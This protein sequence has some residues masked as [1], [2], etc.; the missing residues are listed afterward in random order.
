MKVV[1]AFVPLNVLHLSQEAY[2]GYGRRLQD[3]CDGR[4]VWFDDWPLSECWLYKWLTDY[5]GDPLALPPATATPADRY[6]DPS[7]HVKSN[8]V[9]HSRTQWAKLAA[10][11]YVATDVFVWLDL[12]LLKQGS[13]TGKQITEQHV[14]DFLK[15]VED[16][17]FNDTIPFPG[18]EERKPVDVHGNNWRF[19]GCTHIWPRWALPFIDHAYKFHCRE[20]IRDHQCIPLD[21]AVWPTV[22]ERSGLPFKQYRAEYD[23]T[24]LTEFP[25]DASV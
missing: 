20:F 15:R 22:E 18:I 4:L 10:Q 25:H 6:A 12:G 5:K 3:A 2:K 14:R 1:T 23:Y 19:C 9:Q 13:F 17:N 21:L 11:Q 16:F 8:I 24:Q 7:D